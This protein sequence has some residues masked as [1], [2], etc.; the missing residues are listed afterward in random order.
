[1]PAKVTV[2]VC[3]PLDW[4]EF[5]PD[6]AND[7]RVVDRCYEEITESMQAVLTRLA[8][9]RPNPLLS[10]LASLLPGSS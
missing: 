2:E 8:E 3:E 4:S 6:D 10:R 9:E 7:P 1:M 5:G